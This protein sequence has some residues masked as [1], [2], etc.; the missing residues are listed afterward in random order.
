MMEQT[1]NRNKAEN[2]KKGKDGQGK[3]MNDRREEK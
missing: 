2:K 1:N 3:R